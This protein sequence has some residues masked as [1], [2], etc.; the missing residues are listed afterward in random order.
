[1]L[2]EMFQAG[3]QNLL[4][5]EH[6]RSQQ[7]PLF[8]ETLLGAFLKIA[9]ALIIDEKTDQNRQCR[10]SGAYGRDYHLC[11]RSH[12]ALPDRNMADSNRLFAAV[13]LDKM[14]VNLFAARKSL[15]AQCQPLLGAQ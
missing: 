5:A 9:E 4:N 2:F 12:S 14:P 8:V 10:Q 15:V 1:M 7:I 13:V 6:F 3:I 11:Q